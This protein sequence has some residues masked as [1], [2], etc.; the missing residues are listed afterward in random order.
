MKWQVSKMANSQNGKLIKW[1]VDKKNLI[2]EMAGWWK[3]KLM[4]RLAHKMARWLN[5]KLM[6][7]QLD[8]S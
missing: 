4:K 2:D 1:Q 8:E 5:D 7:H 6:K 3:T